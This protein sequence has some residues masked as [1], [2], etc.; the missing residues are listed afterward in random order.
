MNVEVFITKTN[1]KWVVYAQSALIS[2]ITTKTA[3]INLKMADVLFA[4]GTA[5]FLSI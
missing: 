2:C 5:Q 3:H 1:Q 4:I